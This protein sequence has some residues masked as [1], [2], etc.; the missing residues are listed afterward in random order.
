MGIREKCAMLFIQKSAKQEAA[1]CFEGP[2]TG[3][4]SNP[5]ILKIKALLN[6]GE[7]G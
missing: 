7:E 6:V 3:K 1:S 4:G 5:V 2:P